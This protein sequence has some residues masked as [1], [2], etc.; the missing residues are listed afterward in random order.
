MEKKEFRLSE[1]TRESGGEI[2][3]ER[4]GC[5]E[6][7][8]PELCEAVARKFQKEWEASE[9]RETLLDLQKK[10]IM[11]EAAEKEYFLARIR[12]FLKESG[13]SYIDYP[14]W[15]E[16]PEEAVY[17]ELWGLAGLAEWFTDAWSESSSA[18]II[19]DRIYFMQGG[20]MVKRPQT[21]NK[22]RRSQLI[23]ALLLNSPR[24]KTGRD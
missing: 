18:K 23:R 21:I 4:A 20:R 3:E 15:Y 9:R 16:S 24:E 14:N 11:G 22:E 19:G 17:H 13:I 1:W 7:T 10:A 2:C 6:S 8:F 5:G 12:S